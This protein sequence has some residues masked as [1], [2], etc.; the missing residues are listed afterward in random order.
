VKAVIIVLVSA[1]VLGMYAAVFGD[2]GVMVIAVLNA[3]R[4]LRTKGM[5]PEQGF[6]GDTCTHDEGL[7][8]ESYV[9]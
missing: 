7:L 8:H 3:M 1:G 2:V 6:Q 9:R 4:C 5:G